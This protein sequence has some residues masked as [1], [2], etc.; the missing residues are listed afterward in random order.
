MANDVAHIRHARKCQVAMD[1]L[2]ANYKA[3][4]EWLTAIAFYKALHLVEALFWHDSNLRHSHD[5]QTRENILKNTRKFEH[6]YEQYR[7]LQ[8]AALV[9]RYLEAG[10]AEYDTFEEYMGA[11]K[12]KTYVLG[13]LLVQVEKSVHRLL[14]PSA[15]KLLE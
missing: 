14:P 9:A 6:I 12:V 13:H 1:C 4:P 15:Q 5:H 11:E 7:L 3:H 10:S 8:T 2:A